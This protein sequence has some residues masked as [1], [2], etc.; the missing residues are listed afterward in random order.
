[1]EI[2]STL[3]ESIGIMAVVIFNVGLGYLIKL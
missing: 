3:G 2:G 1:M